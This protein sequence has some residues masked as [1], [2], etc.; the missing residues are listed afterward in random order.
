MVDVLTSFANKEISPKRSGH[1]ETEK[2]E[3]AFGPLAFPESHCFDG[4]KGG[5]EATLQNRQS[6]SLLLPRA[7]QNSAVSLKVCGNGQL[8]PEAELKQ[9]SLFLE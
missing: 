1:L 6:V 7:S 4:S 2:R 3:S 9:L 5:L 8:T